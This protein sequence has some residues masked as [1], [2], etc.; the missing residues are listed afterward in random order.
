MPREIEANNFPIQNTEMSI[1]LLNKV[2]LHNRE[3]FKIYIT[4]LQQNLGI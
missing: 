3:N 4:W 2:R 1:L